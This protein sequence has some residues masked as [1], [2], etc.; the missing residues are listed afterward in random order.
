ME[1][2]LST[3]RDLLGESLIKVNQI[4][5]A[6]RYNG[7]ADYFN[8]T[9]ADSKSLLIDTRLEIQQEFILMDK[10]AVVSKNISF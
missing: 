4:L 10:I 5:K 8:Q 9:P 7:L 1:T 6:N 2:N 3:L